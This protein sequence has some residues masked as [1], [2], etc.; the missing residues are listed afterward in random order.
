[1]VREGTLLLNLILEEKLS[2]FLIDYDVS[3]GLVEYGLCDME[4][5]VPSVLI[6]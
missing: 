6:S 2:T 3:C 1:M 5:Y 4:V